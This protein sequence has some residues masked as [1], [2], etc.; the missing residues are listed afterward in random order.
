MYH[1]GEVNKARHMPQ[2]HN[3]IATKT[4]SGEVHIYDYFKHPTK[5]SDWGVRPNVRL[6]GH[7]SEGY[8]LS[9][10]PQHEGLIVSGSDDGVIC[11]WDINQVSRNESNSIDPLYMLENPH[12]GEEIEDVAWSYFD[13]NRYVS[14]GD[15]KRIM[16]WDTRQQG[17]ALRV[18]DAHPL[19]IMCVDM[20]PFDPYLILTGSMDTQAAVWDQRNMT[21][22]L[23]KLSWHKDALT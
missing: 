12:D 8:G 20:S 3:I 19:E 23:F 14:V 18:D 10:N 9:W 2:S 13:E 16:L 22:C 11:M 7:T 5:P 4:V 21:Q 15:D 6:V 17:A 1:E